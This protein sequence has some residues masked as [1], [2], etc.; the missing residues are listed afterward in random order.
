M[1]LLLNHF[2]GIV[3][4]N[5]NG[6]TTVFNGRVVVRRRTFIIIRFMNSRGIVVLRRLLLFQIIRF[7]AI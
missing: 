4:R 1:T 5:A 7:I 3:Y 2:Y 6:T